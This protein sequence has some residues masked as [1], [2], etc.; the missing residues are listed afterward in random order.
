MIDKFFIAGK[1]TLNIYPE[2]KTYLSHATNNS[3]CP[4]GIRPIS[5]NVAQSE[6]V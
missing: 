1:I 2:I 6:I 4:Q 5:V 3:I